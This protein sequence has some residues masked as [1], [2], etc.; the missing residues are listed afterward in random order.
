MSIKRRPPAR[1][2]TKTNQYSRDETFRGTDITSP[3]WV[4]FMHF[5]WKTYSDTPRKLFCLISD[6]KRERHTHTLSTDI[7]TKIN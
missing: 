6:R 4:N 5:A 1:N 7:W 3:F 2:V